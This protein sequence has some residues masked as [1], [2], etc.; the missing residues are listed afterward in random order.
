M[1]RPIGEILKENAVLVAGIAL[2]VLLILLFTIARVIPAETVDPPTYKVVYAVKS[3]PHNF[4]FKVTDGKLNTTY[5]PPKEN[6]G[7]DGRKTVIYIYNPVSDSLETETL[8]VPDAKEGQTV[9]VPVKKFDTIKLSADT[10]A[11]D[12]Y[13]FKHN[14]YSNTSLVTE[15]FSSRSRY[16]PDRIE[17]DGRSISLRTENNNTYNNVTFIGWV[18]PE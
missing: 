7:G 6:Y 10:K 9:Q 17:K 8:E 13:E 4:D 16:K 11:P 12:G 14:E 2:P 5:T 18:V 1:S 3:Y 15:I